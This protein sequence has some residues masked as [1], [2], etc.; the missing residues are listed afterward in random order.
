MSGLICFEANLLVCDF[1]RQ[2]S[3]HGLFDAGKERFYAAGVS[4]GCSTVG[5]VPSQGFVPALQDEPTGRTHRALGL[6]SISYQEVAPE[7]QNACIG[8]SVNHPHL[9]RLSGK[10]ALQIRTNQVH[11]RSDAQTDGDANVGITPREPESP[12]KKEEKKQQTA[13]HQ[14]HAALHDSES[15][16]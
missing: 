7:G 15:S 10:A 4:C 16:L 5:S 13:L 11:A 3:I 2:D 8:R 1:P 6:C 14:A 9:E 12:F